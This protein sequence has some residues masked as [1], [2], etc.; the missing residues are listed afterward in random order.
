MR[1]SG[2]G[3]G[4]LWGVPL[5]SGLFTLVTVVIL[6]RVGGRLLGIRM[7]WRSD[8]RMGHR[9]GMQSAFYRGEPTRAGEQFEQDRD[10]HRRDERPEQHRRP[11]QRLRAAALA[12][13]RPGGNPAQDQAGEPGQDRAPPAH[14]D[15][16]QAAAHPGQD[17]DGDQGDQPR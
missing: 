16:E 12:V 10:Q 15:P 5:L 8:R 9:D 6:A 7:R 1:L 13:D 2:S 3:F 14:P 17:H 11:R 4:F